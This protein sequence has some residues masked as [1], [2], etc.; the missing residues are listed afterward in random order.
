[1]KIKEAKVNGLNTYFVHYPGAK[2]ASVQYWFRAGSS[3]ESGK[4]LG[5][6][7]FLEHMFFK[8]TKTRP[9]SKIAHEIESF[10]GEINAF[11]S[12]DYTCY[13]I[14]T[15]KRYLTKSVDIL[16]DMVANPEFL[17]SELIPERGVVFEEYRRSVDN[18]YHYNFHNIQKNSFSNWLHRSHFKR[19][20]H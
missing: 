5:I 15:P 20:N 16:S 3:L 12:F 8:G 18:P 14:N 17:E 2:S 13:Y 7:H 4:D 11:T 6:A 1:M 9:G 10:G 19:L